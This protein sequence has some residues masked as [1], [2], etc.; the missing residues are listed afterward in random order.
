[1][2]DYDWLTDEGTQ[3]VRFKPTV[4]HLH[5]KRRQYKLYDL[6]GLKE[7]PFGFGFRYQPVENR[8]RDIPLA[9]S[10]VVISNGMRWYYDNGSLFT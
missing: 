4:N 5:R 3:V 1:M 9:D 6:N 10:D 2:P 7:R 8:L